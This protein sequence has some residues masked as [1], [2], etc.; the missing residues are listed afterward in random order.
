MSSFNAACV[1]NYFMPT[2]CLPFKWTPTFFDALSVSAR[3]SPHAEYQ[4]VQVKKHILSS[5]KISLP[6]FL[7]FFWFGIVLMLGHVE[8]YVFQ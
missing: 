1:E 5:K 2:S 8:T 4:S 3:S 7:I 6:I